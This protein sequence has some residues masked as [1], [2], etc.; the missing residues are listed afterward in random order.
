MEEIAAECGEWWLQL[1]VFRDRER[2]REQILRAAAAGASA[3]VLTVDA[4][5]RGRREAEERYRL[6][7]QEIK[8]YAIFMLDPLGRVITWNAGAERVSGYATEEI[9]GKPHSVFFLPEDIILNT[10]R[11]F[12]QNVN[13]FTQGTPTGRFIAP[14]GFGGCVQ[15]FPGQCGFADRGTQGNSGS[16][17]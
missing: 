15:A 12:N 2:T 10:Q 11:A 3:L 9:L 8:D 6:I 5:F 14:A 13:G 4:Q 1:Y 7:L 16:A 17:A